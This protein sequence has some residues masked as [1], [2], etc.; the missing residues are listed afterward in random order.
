MYTGKGELLSIFP[1]FDP[2][3][4]NRGVVVPWSRGGSSPTILKQLDKSFQWTGSNADTVNWFGRYGEGGGA[5]TSA[6]LAGH[7]IT[8]Y[9]SHG[10][11]DSG[12][13]FAILQAALQEEFGISVAP[14]PMAVVD[15]GLANSE[16]GKPLGVEYW[17][18]LLGRESPI[19]QAPRPPRRPRLPSEPTKPAPTPKPPITPT[20]PSRTIDIDFACSPDNPSHAIDI[21]PGTTRLDGDLLISVSQ[22]PREVLKRHFTDPE[23]GIS[24]LN[25]SNLRVAFFALR[26]NNKGKSEKKAKRV[27]R[28]GFTQ[29]AQ[30]Q[31]RAEGDITAKDG[32]LGGPDLALPGVHR[33]KFTHLTATGATTFTFANGATMKVISKETGPLNSARFWLGTN[34]PADVSKTSYI[35]PIGRITGSLTIDGASTGTGPGPTTPTPP[36]PVATDL[37]E[38]VKDLNARAHDLANQTQALLNMLEDQ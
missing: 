17:V 2:D 19:S 12:E 10:G 27:L 35:P 30:R 13:A 5:P 15:F 25:I 6:E 24:A 28:W 8:T 3:P 1:F 14:S 20:P 38:F 29:G 4:D 31:A 37:I 23:T 11:T 32:Q 18:K 33:I 26:G 22:D 9:G 36:P 7:H 16:D 34:F 21:P